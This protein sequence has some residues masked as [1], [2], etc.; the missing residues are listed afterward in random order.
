V[1]STPLTEEQ[2]LEQE[3]LIANFVAGWHPE[4]I[5]GA[6]VYLPPV[7]LHRLSV[8]IELVH[9]DVELRTRSGL[10]VTIGTYLDRFPELAG[11][12]N[13][14]EN[15]VAA[16]VEL[17]LLGSK[18][19]LPQTLGNYELEHEVGRGGSSVVYRGRDTRD[20]RVVAIKVLRG[21]VGEEPALV[22]RFAREVALSA[23]LR[24]PGLAVAEEIGCEAGVCYLISPFVNGVSMS[25]WAKE[26]KPNG[27]V[28]TAFANICEAVGHAHTQGVL[29][30][31]LSSSNVLVS[32]DDRPVVIDFGLA[33][34]PSTGTLRTRTGGW[35]GTPAYLAPELLA[36]GSPTLATDVYALGVML[37]EALLG[38]LPNA[39]T[40]PLRL[41]ERANTPPSLS[42]APRGLET[43]CLKAM[44]RD[45]RRRYEDATEMGADLR[46]FLA[47]ERILARPPRRLRRPAI[48]LVLLVGVLGLALAV[49][50]QQSVDGPVPFDPILQNWM[51]L[52]DHP[53]VR[54]E[55]QHAL[56]A[57]V[58]DRASAAYREWSDREPENIYPRLQAARLSTIRADVLAE[59]EPATPSA[60]AAQAAARETWAAVAI[61]KPDNFFVRTAHALAGFRAVA[62]SNEWGTPE[63]L[64]PSR[65]ECRRIAE[66]WDGSPSEMQASIAQL[67]RPFEAW[68]AATPATYRDGLRPELEFARLQLAKAA[69]DRADVAARTTMCFRLSESM[70]PSDRLCWQVQ[71]LEAAIST[72]PHAEV[73]ALWRRLVAV[74][75]ERVQTW[76]PFAKRKFSEA[77]FQ[78]S[79]VSISHEAIGQIEKAVTWARLADDDRWLG[80]CLHQAGN[81]RSEEEAQAAFTEALQIRRKLAA[82]TAG[83]QLQLDLSAS[84]YS[85]GRSCTARRMRHMFVLAVRFRPGIPRIGGSPIAW[86]RSRDS[87]D[88]SA[89]EHAAVESLERIEVEQLRRAAAKQFHTGVCRH[90]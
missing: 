76:S 89:D 36:G 62:R 39:N 72:L 5:E 37:F 61:R 74:P 28:A 58:L 49:R 86:P 70:A 67:G 26:R 60:F 51:P 82:S 48:A 43:I 30:R 79:E 59:S 64:D 24:H 10:P 23:R 47:G 20:G 44:A 33:T 78:L 8:L 68:W 84:A 50:P 3:R 41:R 38:R 11:D 14:A 54:N 81:R 34:A 27:T 16:H 69:N 75:D 53:G 12:P 1:K 17:L 6:V 42:D 13:F 32:S 80:V 22:R 40:L 52:L 15:L 45:P 55:T 9:T 21:W 2:W 87:A 73:E 88:D 25:S 4:R 57:D 77:L 19:A 46:R 85:L 63:P 18:T 31:D 66:E 90:A 65:D 35:A 29:H 83:A 7:G 56:R 71:V